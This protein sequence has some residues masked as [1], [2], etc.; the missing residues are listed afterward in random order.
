MVMVGATGLVGKALSA[1]L[2]E[3]GYGLAVFSRD[4]AKARQAVA[5]AAQ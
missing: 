4:P 3:R 2:M 5:A 1:R